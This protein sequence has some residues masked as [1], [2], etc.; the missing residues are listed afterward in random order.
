MGDTF[1]LSPEIDG[2]SGSAEPWPALP[3]DTL[4]S[5]KTAMLYS[6]DWVG[7]RVFPSN[8]FLAEVDG[9]VREVQCVNVRNRHTITSLVIKSPENLSTR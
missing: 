7:N 2:P 9:E 8:I 6:D 3:L 4:V 5:E 1:R